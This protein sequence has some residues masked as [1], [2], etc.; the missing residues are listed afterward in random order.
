MACYCQVVW[1]RTMALSR[2]QCLNSQIYWNWKLEAKEWHSIF[3]W[4]PQSPDLNPITIF[5]GMSWKILLERTSASSVLFSPVHSHYF[6][7]FTAIHFHPAKT[8]SASSDDGTH[9]TLKRL[10]IHWG[11]VILFNFLTLSAAMMQGC[12]SGESLFSS[13]C[14]YLLLIGCQLHTLR[15][16]LNSC[17]KY[18]LLHNND[19]F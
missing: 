4:L 7:Q 8:M 2:W 18:T 14:T 11:K 12:G 17:Q 16:I 19:T 13:E 15:Q 9:P 5:C 10:L 3:F 6:L 1:W